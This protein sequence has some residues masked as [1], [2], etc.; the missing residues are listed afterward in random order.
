HAAPLDLSGRG[1]TEDCQ[2]AQGHTRLRTPREGLPDPMIENQ[3]PLLALQGRVDKIPDHEVWVRSSDGVGTLSTK[4]VQALE[5]RPFV[6]IACI[7]A[8]AVNQGVKAV[9]QARKDFAPSRRDLVVQ[10][11]FSMVNSGHEDAKTRI[12]LRVTLVSL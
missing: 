1:G 4:I 11:F 9:A 5:K 2:I 10:P 12:L 8:T 3:A 6:D 7:G